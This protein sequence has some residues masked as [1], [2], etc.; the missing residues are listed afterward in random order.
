MPPTQVRGAR[1]CAA[2]TAFG[3]LKSPSKNCR[4]S[5]P[6]TRSESFFGRARWLMLA[7]L[8]DASSRT[9]EEREDRGE[10]TLSAEDFF[11]FA[12]QFLLFVIYPKSALRFNPLV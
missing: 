10:G 5:N 9:E 12:T 4:R 3:E 6:P 1:D 7:S 2:V 8:A 11:D